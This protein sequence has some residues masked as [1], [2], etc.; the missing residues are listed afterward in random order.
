[1]LSGKVRDSPF[2]LLVIYRSRGATPPGTPRAAP[3]KCRQRHSPLTSE[4]HH[5][6]TTVHTRVRNH[7]GAA[8][9]GPRCPVTSV[10]HITHYARAAPPEKARPLRMTATTTAVI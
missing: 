10:P 8:N 5:A 4:P 2:P 1:M 6:E 3:I 9:E 7:Y